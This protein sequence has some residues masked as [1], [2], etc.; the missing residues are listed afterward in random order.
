MANNLVDSC[1]LDQR[2]LG[3]AILKAVPDL[4]RLDLV[5]ELLEKCIV[6][7]ILDIDAI[8]ADAG[9]SGVAVFAGDGPFDSAVKIGVVEHEERRIAAELQ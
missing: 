2:A 5:R 4:E 1:V 9:L 8:G 6:D 3:Y 7:A